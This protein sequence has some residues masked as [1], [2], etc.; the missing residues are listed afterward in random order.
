MLDRATAAPSLDQLPA[1]VA[2]AYTTTARSL[3]WV[4]ALVILLMIPLGVVIAKDWGGRLQ[5][6]L[7]GL[8]ES[9]GTLLIPIMVARVV[10]RLRNPPLPL[11]DDIPAPQRFTA[12]AT[13]VGLYAL[14]LAQPVVG[15][16]A[17]SAYRAPI[18]VLDL[19]TLPPIA[20]ENRAFSD[21]LFLV[22]RAMGLA[23]AGLVAMHIGAAVH[24]RLVRR[25]QVLMRMIK[26]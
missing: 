24:H 9:L 6:G 16:I 21:E 17:T 23:I 13:H 7:Y 19:F 18:V 5:D 22:H 25:D 20:P 11:P 10:H 15:W 3:H 14:L 2:P 26:G 8:H 1:A 4:T 12:H